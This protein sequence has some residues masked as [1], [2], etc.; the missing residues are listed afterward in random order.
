[1]Y[2]PPSENLA[3]NTLSGIFS[4]MSE[5]YKI[6]WFNGILDGIS[7]GKS[8]QLFDDIVNRMIAS[9][10]IDRICKDAKT[11]GYAAVEG[12]P[13]LSDE[14]NDFDYQGPVRL[15]QKAGFKEAAREQG[16]AIMRKLL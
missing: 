3:I 6:F 8:V 5:S 7:E 12:Y 14:H 13:K 2:L 11:K 4:D 16:Q 10:F 9:A 1:M 15:Y